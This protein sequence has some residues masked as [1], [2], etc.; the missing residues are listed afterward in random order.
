MDHYLIPVIYPA[1]FTRTLQVMLGGMAIALNL[2]VYVFVLHRWR[3][4]A[5]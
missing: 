3:H 4:R 5:G 2:A 1:E